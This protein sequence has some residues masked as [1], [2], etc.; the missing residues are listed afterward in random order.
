MKKLVFVA[1]S[2]LIM[3]SGLVG[4][5]IKETQETAPAM[6]QHTLND[7]LTD[8]SPKND[9]LTEL[10]QMIIGNWSFERENNF[11]LTFVMTFNEDYTAIMH[12]PD[13]DIELKWK[14]D[15]TKDVFLVSRRDKDDYRTVIYS[16]EDDGRMTITY[17]N[18][19]GIKMKE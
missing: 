17:A 9:S 3:C 4:C 18:T 11:S 2:T 8:A 13:E 14:Y 16:I 15:E 6:E 5:G 7:D 1:L 12:Y 19:I 10:E